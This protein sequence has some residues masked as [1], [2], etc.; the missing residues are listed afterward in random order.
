[1]SAKTLF[2]GESILYLGDDVAVPALGQSNFLFF[3]FGWLFIFIFLCY[4]VGVARFKSFY[5][6]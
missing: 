1:M 2:C 3:V 6:F 4:V 5:I